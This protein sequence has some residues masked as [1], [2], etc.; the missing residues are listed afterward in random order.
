MLIVDKC[1]FNDEEVK[2]LCK[3][4]CSVDMVLFGCMLVLLFEFNVEVV[5]QVF[6]VLGV[7]V[8]IV[9]FDFFIVVDDLNNKEEDVGFGY[10]GEQG[11]V[12]V[13]FYIYVCISCDL[14]VENLGGNE[15][16][17]KCI[18]VVFIEIVLIVLLIG[19]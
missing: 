6:Y 9:E 1:E 7:S 19:K 17:V 13:F 11:F 3:E 8:V 2:F 18:I 14:L 15:E 12:L 10:M 5:C 16:L 4:Q